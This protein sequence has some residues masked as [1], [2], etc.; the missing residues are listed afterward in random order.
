MNIITIQMVPPHR[1]NC[2]HQLIDDYDHY[3]YKLDI[4]KHGRLNS[5]SQSYFPLTQGGEAHSPICSPINC[6]TPDDF[7]IVV[8][9][10]IIRVYVIVVHDDLKI[11]GWGVGF[12]NPLPL[13]FSGVRKFGVS[14]IQIPMEFRLEFQLDF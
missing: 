10:E 11:V 9:Y 13:F 14:F 12:R 2:R 6:S 3:P 5:S 4:I 7:I 1:V 8:V